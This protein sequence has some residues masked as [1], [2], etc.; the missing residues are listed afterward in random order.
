MGLSEGGLRNNDSS[1]SSYMYNISK[2]RRARVKYE[3]PSPNSIAAV[4]KSV[5]NLCNGNTNCRSKW[6]AT[7]VTNQ[8]N[9]VVTI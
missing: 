3:E 8:L 7:A 9:N 6:K 5:I 4:T 1:M 2:G